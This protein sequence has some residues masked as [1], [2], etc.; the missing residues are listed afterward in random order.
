MSASPTILVTGGTGYIGSH[1]CVLLLQAGYQVV[2]LDNLS[3]SQQQ[4]VHAIE[5]VSARRPVFIHGDVRDPAM[6]LHIFQTYEITAVLH[7]A[8]LKAVGESVT[9]PLKYY[10]NNVNGSLQLILALQQAGV[11]KL[12]FSSSAT[13]YGDPDFLPITEQHP[14]RATNPYGHSKRLIEQILTDWHQSQPETAIACLRYFNP[15]GAHPSGLLG[16]NPNNTPN[17]L[18]PY[19]MQVAS[20]QRSH[21]AIFGNDYDTPDGT[22]VRDYLH[23]MDLAQGH[24]LALKKIQQQEEMLLTLNLGTGLGYS[25]LDVVDAAQHATGK[26][27]PYKF[28]ARRPGDIA[29]CWAD[30]RLA[31]EQLGWKAHHDLATMCADAWRWVTKQHQA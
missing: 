23:V 27:I 6:L 3:N 17:N 16:E 18:M 31:Y 12:I 26:T 11:K 1:T 22:G 25:V 10:D 29:A 13:V 9:Q 4:T 30:P 2:I 15:V 24:L 14:L 28:T 7:F 20:G 21:L 5:A 8:G 19:L